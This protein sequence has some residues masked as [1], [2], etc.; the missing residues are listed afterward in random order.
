MIGGYVETLEQ[1]SRQI[2]ARIERIVPRFK[3]VGLGCTSKAEHPCHDGCQ[4][5][6][7]YEQVVHEM[8]SMVILLS[9]RVKMNY[10]EH[11]ELDAGTRF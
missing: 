7:Q 10:S 6:S 1:W 8:E 2:V 3:G 4:G 9:E 11:A 5:S